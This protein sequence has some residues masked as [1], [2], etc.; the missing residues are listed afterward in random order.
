MRFYVIQET[1]TDESGNTTR[2]IFVHNDKTKAR[3]KLEEFWAKDKEDEL[4]FVS[5]INN[6]KQSYSVTR[7]NYI[8]RVAMFMT[9][10][11]IAL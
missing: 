6:A 11:K 9:D 5:A 4:A 2:P 10:G 7:P 1:W 3:Q 8:Y